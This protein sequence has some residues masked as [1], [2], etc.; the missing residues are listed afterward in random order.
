[1]SALEGVENKGG[2]DEEM[3]GRLKEEGV[4][5]KEINDALNRA[6]IKS[7]VSADAENPE[8]NMQ[9]SI[10]RP[11]RPMPLPTEGGPLAEEDLTPPATNIPTR[12]GYTPGAQEIAEENYV[13]QPQGEIYSPAPQ[14]YSTA[15]EYAPQEMYDEYAPSGGITDTDTMIEISEQVFSEKIKT[16]QKHVESMNEFKTLAETKIDHISARLKR[17]ETVIDNLQ[18]TILNKVGAYGGG[19]ETIKKEMSMMQDSFGKMVGGLAEKKHHT[20]HRIKK[21]TTVIHRSARKTSKK[22]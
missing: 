13:P 19:L 10:M 9:P 2:S 5:P 11:E 20:T 7:A 1:M 18:A 3:I 6:K 15:Q 16:I 12:I 4:A 17:I 14:E 22:R 8:G 21:E